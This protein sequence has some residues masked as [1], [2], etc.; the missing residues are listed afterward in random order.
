[1]VSSCFYSSELIIFTNVYAPSNYFEK[2]QPWNHISFVRSS[3]P[4]FPWIMDGDFNAIT[5]LEDKIGW[6]ARLDSSGL[7]AP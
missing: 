3:A 6:V 7:L 1:M 5:I 2:V 4:L